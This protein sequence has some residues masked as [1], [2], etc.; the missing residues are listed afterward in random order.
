MTDTVTPERTPPGGAPRPQ[1]PRWR[2]PKT[3]VA[4]LVVLAVGL[5]G[6]TVALW[7]TGQEEQT[8]PGGASEPEAPGQ[9]EAVDPDPG[10]G[11]APDREAPEE[12]AGL[13]WAPPELENPEVI[14][15]TEDNAKLGLDPE[16][17]YILDLPDDRPLEAE[18]GL[19]VYQGRNVVVIG[20]EIRIPE[21]VQGDDARGIYFKGQTGTVHIEGVAITGRTLG[22]GIQLD[23]REGAVVQIQNVRMDPLRGDYEGH[24]ADAIQTWAGPR[25]LRVDGL[26]VR[27]EYQA[28]FFQP[29]QHFE[30][31]E[32]ELFDL[33]R[34]DVEGLEG[35]AFLAWRQSGREWPLRVTD[36][37]MQPYDEDAPADK[38]LW[39]HDGPGDTDW[40][41]HVGLPPNGPFVP[42]GVAGVDYVSPGYRS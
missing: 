12:P 20:G 37:W 7:S 9:G 16:R 14:Q 42:E 35:S 33:R 11:P 36:V 1:P 13:S 23:Q 26:S 3:L 5:T 38:W 8:T 27:T 40:P 28:F 32:P 15:I 39:S 10:A 31:P 18:G 22:E 4:L 41:V 30:G 34:I 17:D 6:L 29:N 2:D 19:N 24:H 25:I 21:H